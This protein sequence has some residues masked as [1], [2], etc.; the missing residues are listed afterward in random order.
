ML[1]KGQTINWALFLALPPR[2]C[3]LWPWAGSQNGVHDL[4]GLCVCVCVCVHGL[5]GMCVFVCVC[6]CVCV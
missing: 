3:P 1:V 4:T 6:V 2:P 5:T